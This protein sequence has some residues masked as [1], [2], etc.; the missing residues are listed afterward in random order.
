MVTI[1]LSGVTCGGCEGRIS[2]AVRALDADADLRFSADRG[3]VEIRS[4]V[5]AADL[6]DIIREQGYGAEPARSLSSS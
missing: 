2:R 1:L 3:A 6:A 5:S 4:E